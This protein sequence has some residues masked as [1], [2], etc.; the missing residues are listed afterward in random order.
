ML[1]S[2]TD[3]L[4]GRAT[5]KWYPINEKTKLKKREGKVLE[6]K[7]MVDNKWVSLSKRSALIKCPYRESAH[8]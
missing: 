1:I 7:C 5:T 6:Y 3:R 2:V 8:D 4:E